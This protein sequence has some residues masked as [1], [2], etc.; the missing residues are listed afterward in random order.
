MSG[1][2][3]EWHRGPREEVTAKDKGR[4][5]VIR[6]KNGGPVIRQHVELRLVPKAPK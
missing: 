1:L 6:G 5:V 2:R 4:D 3:R